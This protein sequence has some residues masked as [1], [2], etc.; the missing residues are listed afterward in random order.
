MCHHNFLAGPRPVCCTTA[1]TPYSSSSAAL[2]RVPHIS[3]DPR[4]GVWC[5]CCRLLETAL[6]EAEALFK[7]CGTCPEDSAFLLVFFH[8]LEGKIIEKLS[9]AGGAQSRHN[10]PHLHQTRVSDERRLI[11]IMQVFSNLRIF[12]LV[13]GSSASHSAPTQSLVPPT[14]S[15]TSLGAKTR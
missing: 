11:G 8:T 1:R 5:L 4:D 15:G 12:V 13:R 14:V 2:R 7:S 10:V 6:A 9:R 3:R